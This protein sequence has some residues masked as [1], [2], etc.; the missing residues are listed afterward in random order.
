[1]FSTCF[2]KESHYGE[3]MFGFVLTCAYLSWYPSTF[4]QTNSCK[5]IQ[6]DLNFLF[7]S[8]LIISQGETFPTA[9]PF[10]TDYVPPWEKDIRIE[11]ITAEFSFSIQDYFG[12]AVKLGE[13][14]KRPRKR[15]WLTC[16]LT[17]LQYQTV[18]YF[19]LQ[20]IK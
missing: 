13:I 1:M 3:L 18:L 14:I 17:S 10:R 6:Q 16:M 15:S 4:K 19:N 11:K 7:S 9:L 2:Y 20:I 5:G 8:I 12:I